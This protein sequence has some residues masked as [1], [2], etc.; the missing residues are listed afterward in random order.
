M[1]SIN[2]FAI[3]TQSLEFILLLLVN[4]GA[5]TFINMMKPFLGKFLDKFEICGTQL[6]K[7]KPLMLR[8]IGMDQLPAKYGGG[9]TKSGM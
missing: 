5:E 7:C 1:V 3:A 9:N 8:K 4:Y 2:L 6:A